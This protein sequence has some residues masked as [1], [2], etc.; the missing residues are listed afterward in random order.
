MNYKKKFA[1]KLK[2]LFFDTHKFFNHVNNKFILLLR[3]DVYSYGY[4]DIWE[5]FNET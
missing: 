3:K 1:E 2:K 4:M 5:K